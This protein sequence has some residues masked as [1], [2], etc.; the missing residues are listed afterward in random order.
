LVAAIEP[1][2]AVPANPTPF[3]FIQPDKSSFQAIQVGDER[4]AHFETMDGYTPHS[5]GLT[6]LG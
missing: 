4:G 1:V 2:E 5:R 6:H 3:T